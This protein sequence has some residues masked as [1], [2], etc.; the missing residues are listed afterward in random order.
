[1]VGGSLAVLWLRGEDKAEFVSQ[2]YF[3]AGE[4]CQVRDSVPYQQTLRRTHDG[5]P[6]ASMVLLSGGMYIYEVVDSAVMWAPKSVDFGACP[7]LSSTPWKHVA[8]QHVQGTG[9]YPNSA[10]RVPI[11]C[12]LPQSGARAEYLGTCRRKPVPPSKGCEPTA[13]GTAWYQRTGGG[14]GLHDDPYSSHGNRSWSLHR[15][16]RQTPS[17]CM[18]CTVSALALIVIPT[19]AHLPRHGVESQASLS[20]ALYS[21]CISAYSETHFEQPI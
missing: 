13:G 16:V 11:P 17:L 5:C 15:S 20:K 14:T 7:W 18:D 8:A 21:L 10:N 2:L 19:L 4:S 9:R 1:M 6:A 3:D 12:Q